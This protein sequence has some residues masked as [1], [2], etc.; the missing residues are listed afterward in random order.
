MRRTARDTSASGDLRQGAEA[1]ARGEGGDDVGPETANKNSEYRVLHPVLGVLIEPP[2]TRGKKRSAQLK[3]EGE[4]VKVERVKRRAENTIALTVLVAMT[5][6]G[7]EGCGGWV[8]LEEREGESGRPWSEWEAEDK[9][10]RQKN[11][12]TAAAIDARN[13]QD[14]RRTQSVLTRIFHKRTGGDGV[15]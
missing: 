3:A 13:A 12:K 9:K 14:K 1:G 8:D 7:A 15:T 10:R 11:R 4:R 5:V 2:T 6:P